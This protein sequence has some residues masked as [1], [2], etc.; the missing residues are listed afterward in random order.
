[1][2]NNVKRKKDIS[3]KVN[4]LNLYFHAR[5]RCFLNLY[6]KTEFYEILTS[7]YILKKLLLQKVN[8]IFIK[9][10]QGLLN[11]ATKPKIK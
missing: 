9:G 5:L 1:M 11:N 8:N 3:K 10:K 6:T 4:K 2:L 7:R